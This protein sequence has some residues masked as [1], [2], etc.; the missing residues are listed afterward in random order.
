MVDKVRDVGVRL[1]TSAEICGARGS[2]GITEIDIKYKSDGSVETL[3]ADTVVAALGFIANIGPLAD[4]GLNG[5]APRR[6]R[7]LNAHQP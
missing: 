7:Y 5:E 2:D 3:Q 6:R 4:W 1:V